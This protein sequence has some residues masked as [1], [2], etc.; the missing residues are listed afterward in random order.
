MVGSAGRKPC[1]PSCLRVDT[2]AA[3]GRPGQ[4]ADLDDHP[5]ADAD[6]PAELGCSG[7]VDHDTPA[8]REVEVWGHTSQSITAP[9]GTL[10]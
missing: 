8:N 10:M 4:R 1:S 6:V 5:G 7:P 3:E 2:G 9:V